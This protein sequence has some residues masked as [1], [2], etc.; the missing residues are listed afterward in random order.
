MFNL[1]KAIEVATRILTMPEQREQINLYLDLAARNVG[2]TEYF[3]KQ[4]SLDRKMVVLGRKFGWKELMIFNINSYKHERAHFDV[5]HR[6]DIKTRLYQLRSNI[7]IF[8]VMD[9]NFNQ[10]AISREYTL[11]KIIEI[12]KEMLSASFKNLNELN[13]SHIADVLFYEVLSGEKVIDEVAIRRSF[14]KY[15]WKVY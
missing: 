6:Y 1:D 11:D 10:V 7:H 9:I 2:V 14:G 15:Q 12:L 4:K 8:Y 5:W 3:M 13:E